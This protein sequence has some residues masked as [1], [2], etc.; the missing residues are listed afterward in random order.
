MLLDKQNQF[1]DGQAISVLGDTASS[2]V[3]DLKVARDIGGAVTDS[4]YLLC[5]VTTA[6][7]SG[8]SA[9]MAV[10]VQGSNTEGSGYTDLYKSPAVAV[11][12]LVQGYKFL[13]GPL[14]SMLS[15]ALY[16]YLRLNF[17]VAVASMTAGNITAGLTPALQHSPV[18]GGGYV[19]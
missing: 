5:Q 13:Q 3:I 1:S 7:T 12:S 4:L 17:T 6:F 18:Y 11:A 19:A 10:A 16:R 2:N 8:G 15:T 9:T 14:L